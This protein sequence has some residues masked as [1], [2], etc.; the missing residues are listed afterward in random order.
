V[1]ELRSSE[2]LKAGSQILERC[3]L[4]VCL[5][6]S[7][8]VPSAAARAEERPSLR[9]AIALF[10]EG[11]EVEAEHELKR[12]LGTH[13]NASD[14][15]HAHVYLGLLRLNAL[16]SAAAHR[17]FMAALSADLLVELPFEASPKAETLFDQA[18]AE[19]RARSRNGGASKASASSSSRAVSEAAVAA[20][21]APDPIVISLVGAGAVAA[22]AGVIFVGLSAASLSS[23]KSSKSA[24]A[25]IDGAQTSATEQDVGD[26][27]LIGAG[28]ALL[29]GGV[30]YLGERLTGASPAASAKSAAHALA[31]GGVSF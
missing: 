22:V 29:A 10:N 23:A 11:H 5:G 13:P 30:V 24:P 17:E 15:A 27:L 1:V 4:C 18:R 7:L 28:G 2:A 19:V 16:D 8:I 26:W 31:V 25:A 9:Q 14:E 3:C 20:P 12:L 6:L 21:L